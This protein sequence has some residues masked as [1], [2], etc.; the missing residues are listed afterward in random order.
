MSARYRHRIL[1]FIAVLWMAAL[2]LPTAIKMHHFIYEHEEFECIAK[3]EVHLHQTEVD[4]DFDFFYISPQF[5][6]NKK[7]N[8]SNLNNC[9]KLRLDSY[10]SMNVLTNEIAL[11]TLRAPPLS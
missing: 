4:C 11:P 2:V 5:A 10:S 9:F 1:G 3:G 8:N 7:L 6:D